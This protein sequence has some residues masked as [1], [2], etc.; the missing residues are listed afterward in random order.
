MGNRVTPKDDAYHEIL[1]VGGT[2]LLDR[3]PL[4][5]SDIRI[6]SLVSDS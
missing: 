3:K 1:G 4:S 2:G 6:N 5:N